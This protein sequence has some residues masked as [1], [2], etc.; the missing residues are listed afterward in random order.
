MYRGDIEAFLRWYLPHWDAGTYISLAAALDGFKQAEVG[1]VKPAT[2][3]RKLAAITKFFEVAVR[4]GYLDQIHLDSIRAVERLKVSGTKTGIWLSAE[5][6]KQLR[7]APDQ[8]TEIGL[9][10]ALVLYILIS[11]GLRRAEA[12]S[13][14][15]GDF[16]WQENH[17]Q[18]KNIVGKGNKVRTIPVAKETID[19]LRAVGWGESEEKVLYR[20]LKNGRRVPGLTTQAIWLIVKRYGKVC[21]FPE[22]LAPHDLRRSIAHI[23]FKREDIRAA[24]ALLGH[25]SVGTTEKYLSQNVDLEKMAEALSLDG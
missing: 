14:T 8:D 19:V 2:V 11:C 20:V 23:L 13:L 15:W 4:D 22:Q 6:L 16:V 5:Q 18:I 7:E 1:R 12:A 9:R 25:S 24:Q 21:G 17:W 10:D 3:N